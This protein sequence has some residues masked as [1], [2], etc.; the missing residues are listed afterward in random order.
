MSSLNGV[1]YTEMYLTDEEFAVVKAMREQEAMVDVKIKFETEEEAVNYTENFPSR[2]SFW[3]F[4]YSDIGLATTT[5]DE[6]K[7]SIY[8][9]YAKK[10]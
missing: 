5:T 2:K 7:V 6:Q 1:N 3:T 10:D 4:N 9:K 8:A